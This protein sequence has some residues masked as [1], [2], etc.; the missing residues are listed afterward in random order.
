MI[1]SRMTVQI[2]FGVKLRADVRAKVRLRTRA[3]FNGYRSIIVGI[4]VSNGVRHR[5]L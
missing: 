2:R 3:N 1:T 5:G 4:E